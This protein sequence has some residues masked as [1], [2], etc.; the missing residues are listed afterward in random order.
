[1]EMKDVM[2]KNVS[3]YKA[4]ASALEKHAGPN[5]KVL[6]V[7]NPANTNALILKEFAPS[8][9]EKNITCLTRLDH[10]RALG[11]ISKRIHVHV[12]DVKNAKNNVHHHCAAVRCIH[13]LSSEAIQCIICCKLWLK[14][15]EFSREKMDATAKELMEEKSLA[16]SCLK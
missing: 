5:S 13:H 12:G 11:Q 10:N 1:M 9:S 8:I 14:I 2:S 7:A 6:V 4:Q 16:Y 3:I 15:D